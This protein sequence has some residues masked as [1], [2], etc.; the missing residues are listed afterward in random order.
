MFDLGCMQV[1]WLMAVRKAVSTTCTNTVLQYF[2][3][4]YR[5]PQERVKHEYR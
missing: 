2:G 5:A 3:N 4:L 1:H